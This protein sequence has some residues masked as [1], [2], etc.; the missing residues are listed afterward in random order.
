MVK[1][2]DDVLR[3]VNAVICRCRAFFDK[4]FSDFSA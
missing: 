1:E 3:E 4:M 2:S